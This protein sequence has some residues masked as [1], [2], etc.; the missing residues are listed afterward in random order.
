MKLKDGK[1]PKITNSEY[2]GDRHYLSSSA[3]K[4]ILRN[5]EEY[6]N[7]YILGDLSEE[8]AHFSFGNYVHTLI[9]EPENVEAEYAIYPGAVRR[10][11]LYDEFKAKSDGKLLIT[12]QEG[13]L[14]TKIME[15]YNKHPLASLLFKGGQAEETFACQ[16]AGVPIKV[17]LDYLKGDMILDVKTTGS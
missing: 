6:Y 14:A 5:P 4:M 7:K 13:A 16:L 2:H 15:A 10:G 11:K 9:L 12:A 8:K 3:L 17:R 1:N